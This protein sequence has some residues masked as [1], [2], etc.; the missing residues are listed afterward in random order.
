LLLGTFELTPLD[1]AQLY[2][3]LANGGFKSNLRAVRAVLGADGKALKAFN[4]DV[5]PVAQPDAVFAVQM[6]MEQVIQRGTGVAAESILPSGVVVAGKSGTSS[7]LRDSW[8]AGFS[9]NAVAV[10]WVGYDDDRVTGLTGSAGALGVWDRLLTA[11]GPTSVSSAMPDTLHPVTIDYSTG[12][13]P[14]ASCPSEPVTVYVPLSFTPP[15]A[16]PGCSEL[17]ATRPGTSGVQPEPTLLDR[18]GKWL[19]GITHH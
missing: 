8:F 13:L 5:V 2:T 6:M 7:D 4:V 15:A 16:P 18:A 19:Q 10:V 17:G 11:I 1:V 9:G 3:G 12:Y 14:S